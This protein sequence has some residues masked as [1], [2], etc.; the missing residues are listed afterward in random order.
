MTDEAKC[1]EVGCMTPAQVVK[2]C[3]ESKT[4]CWIAATMIAEDGSEVAYECCGGG[5][6]K[7][8]FSLLRKNSAPRAITQND[9]PSSLTWVRRSMV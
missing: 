2:C 7:A 4:E 5:G 6:K 9:V 3:E 8:R 1:T